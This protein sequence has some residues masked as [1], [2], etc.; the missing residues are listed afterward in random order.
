[1]TGI[2][3]VKPLET[4]AINA[5]PLNFLYKETVKSNVGFLK[6]KMRMHRTL[7]SYIEHNQA[8]QAQDKMLNLHGL[9]RSN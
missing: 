3:N 1:M 7:S 9:V 8:M 4:L 2:L 6:R 5:S